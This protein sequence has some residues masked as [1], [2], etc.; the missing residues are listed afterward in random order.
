MV[1]A[2]R[3]KEFHPVLTKIQD[4]SRQRGGQPWRES[5][6]RPKTRSSIG[7]R[8]FQQQLKTPNLRH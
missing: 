4:P 2:I 7:I 6:K 3:D 1:E 8:K 5:Y